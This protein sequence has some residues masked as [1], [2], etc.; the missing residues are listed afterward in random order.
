MTT[1]A[2]LP[3]IA[4]TVRRQDPDRFLTA[5]FAPPGRRDAL[6]LL[7][8]FNI[9]IAR[10]RDVASEPVLALIRLQWWREV[11]E[12]EVRRHELATPLTAALEAGVLARAD[13][14]AMIDAR[15]QEAEPSMPDRGTF[16]RYL[17]GTAG[18]LAVA[19]ARVLGAS[20]P[21]RFRLAGRGYGLGGQLRSVRALASRGRCQL[22]EDA[23]AAHG[24]TQHEVVA[25]PDLAAL[26]P[27]LVQLAREGLAW[28]PPLRLPRPVIAAALPGVLARRDLRRVP[29]PARLRGLDDKLAVLVAAVRGVV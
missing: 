23:L 18:A 27:V 4:E 5:L 16:L 20:D 25:D 17:D 3:A 28:L 19:A 14:S 29:A 6:M 1:P 9:E 10:A 13:L 11:V 26:R 15:A 8:A 12:G 2:S 24:L 21:E 22:P 7:Y